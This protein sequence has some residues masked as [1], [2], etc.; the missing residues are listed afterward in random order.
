M[1]RVRMLS[2]SPAWLATMV[3]QN[4]VRALLDMHLDKALA[5]IIGPPAIDIA[6]RKVEGL[7]GN[8]LLLC[9]LFVEAHMRDFR[10]GVGTPGDDEI[11]GFFVRPREERILQHNARHGVGGVGKLILGGD[12]A[13]GIDM[14]VGG[15]QAVIDLDPFF[16]ILY[17]RRFQI[18]CFQIGRAPGRHQNLIDCNGFCL[19]VQFKDHRL[20]GVTF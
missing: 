13:G 10:I 11:A 15:A 2:I 3:A 6:N 1:A 19:S 8:T 14:R 18:Q 17:T 5:F 7:N 20:T 16:V 9:F 4:F 12:I